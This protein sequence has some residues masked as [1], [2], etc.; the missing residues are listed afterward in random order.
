MS[1]TGGP[2]VLGVAG[3][4]IMYSGI[5]GATIAATLRAV[6]SGDLTLSNTES[7]TATTSG[8][9]GSSPSGGTGKSGPV[10]TGTTLQNGTT[11]YKF[12]RANGYEPIQAA[13]AIA[14]M[15]GES[16]WNPESIGDLG[17]GLMGWNAP[18]GSPVN[19]QGLNNAAT[20]NITTYGGTCHAAGVGNNSDDADMQSQLDAIL[21][22][23]AMKAG[24]AGA[25]ALMRGAGSVAGA[26]NI[27]GPK[28]EAFGINDVHQEGI[29]TAYQIAKSVDGSAINFPAN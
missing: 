17:C 29:D 16:T 21:K 4:L 10:S 20:N 6:L 26:A 28:I 19:P 25:V 18:P 9:S 2:I 11:I 8:G 27:W 15:W 13:G 3:G 24:G 7:I 14:S 5:K 23:V 22:Y 1:L 12:L